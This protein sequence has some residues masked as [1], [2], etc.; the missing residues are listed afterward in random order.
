V[1]PPGDLNR[2]RFLTRGAV[3]AGVVAVGGALATLPDGLI[4]SL[5]EPRRRGSLDDVEHVV[6]LMQE[7][8]SFDHYYGTLPGVRGFNDTATL[9]SVFAQPNPRGGALLPFHVDTQRVDGQRLVDLDHSWDGTHTAWAGGAY[10]EWIAAKT[11]FTMA[12]FAQT[13][14]PYHYA[15]ADA[16]TI[17]DHY[18]CSLLGPTT[19][20]R[21]HLFT[22]T[23]DPDGTAGGPAIANPHDYKPVYRWTTYP[24]RLQAAGVSWRVYANNEVG[25][26]DHE[27]GYLGDY[28]DNPLWLFQAYHDALASPDPARRELAE[29]A[30]VHGAW[31]P[32]SGRGHDVDHVLADFVADCRAGTL[33]RVS[34]VVAPYAYC[35]HPRARPV[36]GARYVDTVLRAL[37]DNSS[38]W[39]STVLFLNYDENDGFFDHVLPPVAPPG[40]PLEY[41]GGRPIGLGPRVPMTVISPWSRGGW[42][43]SEVY[44]HTSVIRF[45]ER[46]T[47]VMEPNISDWRRAVTGDLTAA[48]DFQ[49][50]TPRLPTLP[51]TA[52]LQLAVDQRQASLPPPVVPNQDAQRMPVQPPGSRPARALPY[53]PVA[54][55]GLAGGTLTVSLENHGSRPVQLAVYTGGTPSSHLLD[56][57]D[58]TSVPVAVGGGY[59][60]SVHGPNGFLRQFR[61]GA[62]DSSIQVTLAP[63][64]PA[65]RCRRCGRIA[66]LRHGRGSGRSFPLRPIPH[67]RR[68]RP[69]ELAGRGHP[70]RDR[71]HHR[72][73]DRVDRGQY[74]HPSGRNRGSARPVPK[75]S[76]AAPDHRRRLRHAQ[77]EGTVAHPGADHHSLVR[78]A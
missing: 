60:V 34:Y 2:R 24:E 76:V 18:F 26:G 39:E 32:S 21:L 31:L 43:S 8:R 5:G 66:A 62:G 65:D 27:D 48:F 4:H 61:G 55:L 40:T 30:N 36:D 67:V 19:P 58:A 38:L 42:V 35:E 14:I 69:A 49:A 51:D 56:G 33:P 23:I 12:H 74:R 1:T 64:G 16:F 72:R 17:C 13:D 7:N 9:A 47:G 59:D 6:I 57:S 53:Q 44:D 25:D 75:G 28:G 20:N 68:G 41:V 78:A 70:F 22:G 54:N 71:R 63:A 10:D 45:L 15:L 73:H 29:R 37:F 11:E 50:H 3:A 46:W 77:S 52:A